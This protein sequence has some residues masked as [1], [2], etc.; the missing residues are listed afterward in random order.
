M[1]IS[2]SKAVKIAQIVDLTVNQGIRVVG[3]VVKVSDLEVLKKGDMKEL[4]KQDVVR[5]DETG[6]CRMVLW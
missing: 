6:S 1:L 2:S 4:K 3:K 5:G